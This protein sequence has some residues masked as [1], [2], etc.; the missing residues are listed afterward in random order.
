MLPPRCPTC[1]HCLADIQIPFE[2]EKN[3]II[4]NNNL[5]QDEKNKKMSELL[6]KLGLNKWCCRMRV[7]SYVD[8]AK[9][10]L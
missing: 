6:T 3:K 4:G 7:I 1:G 10:V 5:N 9:I 8:L 2:E